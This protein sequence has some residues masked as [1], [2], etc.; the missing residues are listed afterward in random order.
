[1]KNL[2]AAFLGALV[3]A[4]CGGVR[5]PKS[6]VLDFPPPAP[7]P[8]PPNGTLGRVV[9]R[10]FRCPDYLCEGRITYRATP[11]EVGFYEYHRW[12]MDP[13]EAITQ[14]LEDALRDQ[15]LFNGVALHEHGSE[16]DYVLSGNLEQLEEVDQGH[17]IF[18]VCTIS[19]QLLD[20]QTRSVVWSHTASEKVPVDKRNIAGVVSSLSAAARTVA[21]R[22]VKSMAEELPAT[23]AQTRR[24]ATTSP[25]TALI[26]P[27]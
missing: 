23:V 22:L 27:R 16:A 20:T 1:M 9:I 25:P 11:E 18:G 14:Y 17:E 13:R 5:Y 8:V 15:S 21:D 4:G 12:A 10:E 24:T 3:L 6:Y 7:R 19:A 26:Q 2:V